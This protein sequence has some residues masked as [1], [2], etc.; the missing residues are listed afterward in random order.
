MRINVI[1]SRRSARGYR[2]ILEDGSLHEEPINPELL[3]DE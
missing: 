1:S 2:V 3:S